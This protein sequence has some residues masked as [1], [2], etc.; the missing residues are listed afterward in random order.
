MDE[1]VTHDDVMTHMC[2]C[3][4][5]VCALLRG[6]RGVCTRRVVTRCEQK[7]A[8][9]LRGACYDDDDVDLV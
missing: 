4:R 3:Q 1:M 5:R 9:Q 7:N 2:G 8:L 6:A